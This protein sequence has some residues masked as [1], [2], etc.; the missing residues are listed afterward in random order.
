[1]GRLTSLPSAVVTDDSALGGAILEKS[2][3][4]T[5]ISKFIFK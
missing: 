2:L 1:M 4:F 5:V 3:R